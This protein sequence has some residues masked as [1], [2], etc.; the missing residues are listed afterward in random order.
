MI[1]RLV[2]LTGLSLLATF[3]LI[4]S[5]PEKRTATIRLEIWV[6]AVL[7]AALL[8]HLT[9]RSTPADSRSRRSVTEARGAP[10][11][12]VGGRDARHRAHLGAVAAGTHSKERGRSSCATPYG[13]AGALLEAERELP[14][15]I[16]GWSALIDD[17]EAS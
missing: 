10:E 17:L 9:R 12:A 4:A 15:T 3:V 1:R 16:E 11:R 5:V 8:L 14:T 13:A 6:L 7:A 2:Q